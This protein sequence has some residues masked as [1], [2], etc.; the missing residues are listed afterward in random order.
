M[1]KQI[2][3]KELPGLEKASCGLGIAAMF[4][5]LI[6]SALMILLVQQVS[7]DKDPK[8]LGMAVFIAYAVFT[9]VCLIHFIQGIVTFKKLESYGALFTAMLTG[10][11]V[12]GLLVNVQLMAAMMFS[13][14]GKEGMVPKITGEGGVTDFMS[15]QS[16]AWTM[17]IAGISTAFAV[18]IIDMIRLA[19][20]R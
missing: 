19:R 9:V 6:M 4:L 16:S 17:M 8:V 5:S 14:I 2:K 3:K 18:G 10:I 20:R 12:F 1:P 15:S 13:A 11:S 7:A